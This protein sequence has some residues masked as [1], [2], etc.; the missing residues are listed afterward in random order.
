[1][2][3]LFKKSMPQGIVVIVQQ[4]SWDPD[5]QMPAPSFPGFKKIYLLIS[6]ILLTNALHLIIGVQLTQGPGPLRDI[7]SNGIKNSVMNWAF[8]G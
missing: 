5:S 3:Q 7:L 1:M 8:I 4:C 6:I 2:P